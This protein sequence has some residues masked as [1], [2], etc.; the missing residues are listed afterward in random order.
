MEI[1][2]ALLFTLIV[3]KES[4]N[5]QVEEDIKSR[6][7]SEMT[8]E[9]GAHRL[10]VESLI[11]KFNHMIQTLANK[12]LFELSLH[13]II[14]ETPLSSQS[15]QKRVYFFKSDFMKPSFPI[16]SPLPLLRF[17]WRKHLS[18]YTLYTMCSV[19]PFRV[20]Y[21]FVNE[22]SGVS[23]TQIQSFKSYVQS[24][25][26]SVVVERYAHEIGALLEELD[27]TDVSVSSGTRRV[28]IRGE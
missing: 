26:T 6:D 4:E 18:M 2:K 25:I 20:Q 23:R 21:S 1:Q 24:Y 8:E 5:I 17:D 13:Q 22:I 3:C 14:K 19:L 12:N 16:L 15:S 7:E 28:W 9:V 10:E 27:I 11:E